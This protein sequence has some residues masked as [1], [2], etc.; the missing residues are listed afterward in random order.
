VWGACALLGSSIATTVRADMS[1]SPGRNSVHVSTI[2]VA[3]PFHSDTLLLTG[4][5]EKGKRGRVVTLQAMLSSIA[6]GE[7]AN[8]RPVINGV[9]FETTDDIGNGSSAGT[10]CA[11]SGVFACSLNG[12]WWIDLDAAEA[13]NPGEFIGKPLVIELRGGTNH[14]GGIGISANMSARMEKK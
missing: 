4:T 9:S 10:D 6:P 11:A 7:D 2:G 3:V 14:L 5:I 12:S 1:T 8:M 13:A